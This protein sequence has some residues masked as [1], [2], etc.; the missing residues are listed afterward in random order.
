M[1]QMP[2]LVLVPVPVQILTHHVLV[3]H[4][5]PV[6]GVRHQGVRF[7]G[8]L[9]DQ[10]EEIRHV[11]QRIAQPGELC[12]LFGSSVGGRDYVQGRLRVRVEFI[13]V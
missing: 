10:P 1:T 13:S 11:L 12:R 3:G 8:V 7:V 2:V 4:S 6:K 9:D 5:N